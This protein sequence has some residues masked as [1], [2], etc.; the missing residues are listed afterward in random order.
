[1]KSR[2]IAV[3]L[4]LV[5]GGILGGATGMMASMD[6]GS[7]QCYYRVGVDPE[8]SCSTCSDSCLGDGYKCCTITVE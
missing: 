7:Q 1:M 6:S 5:A 4:A 2:S 8:N 3:A